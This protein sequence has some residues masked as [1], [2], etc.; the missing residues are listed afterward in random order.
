MRL[1]VG[2]RVFVFMAICVTT[3]L[4][5]SPRV[6]AGVFDPTASY[7]LHF[8]S[9]VDG[10][11]VITQY[12]GTSVS[13]DAGWTLTFQ[14]GHDIVIFPAIDAPPGSQE[15]VDAITTASRPIA[16]N[17]DP[18]EDFVKIRNEVSTSVGFGG[19]DISYYV[20]TESDYFA[21]MA[22]ASYNRDLMN[23]NLNLSAGFSY[24]WDA[25]EPLADQDTQGVADYRRTLHWNVVATH[26]TTPTTVFRLGVEANTVT[27]L[28]HDPYRNV[29]VAGTNVPEQHPDDRFRRDLFVRVSQ[30][31]TNR[32]SIKVDYR[33]YDDDW[34]VTSHT[35]GGKLSQYITDNVAVRY[36][37]RY[38]TQL[39]AMFFQEDYTTAGGINGFQTGDYRLGE[40]GAHLFGGQILWI[41]DFFQRTQVVFTYERY[42]NSNN[43]TADIFE[44][45]LK[46]TF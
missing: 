14:W 15:A 22:S 45:G 21:Q 2:I 18:Y 25:I 46:V 39:P 7:T 29:Y 19:Y 41:P 28:Q 40:Y 34:G 43:F 37:Y 17:S 36:R 44:T 10:L 1:Q 31:I 12:G 3:S 6:R 32:S 38:Y 9:D 24:S 42:F 23:D 30:Y 11:D 5:W 27:G 26:I 16:N 20:S 4:G 13:L 33:F 35:V 8:F